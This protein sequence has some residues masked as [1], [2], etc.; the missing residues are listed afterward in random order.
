MASAR[1]LASAFARR[2]DIWRI[3]KLAKI[4]ILPPLPPDFWKFDY[5]LPRSLTVDNGR[6]TKADIELFNAGLISGG[7][8]TGGMGEDVYEVIDARIAEE[9]YIND[10]A[11]KAGVDPLRIRFLNNAPQQ[12]GVQPP[13]SPTP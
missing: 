13:I 1:L 6:D 10:E 11:K 9:K 5:Q 12:G 2:F 8:L 3:A 7:T 4:G